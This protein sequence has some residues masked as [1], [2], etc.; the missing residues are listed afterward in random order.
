MC[1][2][3]CECKILGCKFSSCAFEARVPFRN[4]L[5]HLFFRD[6][7]NVVCFLTKVSGIRDLNPSPLLPRSVALNVEAAWLDSAVFV[8]N[9]FFGVAEFTLGSNATCASSS[10]SVIG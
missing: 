10:A 3:T 4:A 6:E 7:Q 8:E 2:L 5:S 1:R 9:Q